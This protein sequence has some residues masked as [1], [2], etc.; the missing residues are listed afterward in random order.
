MIPLEQPEILAHII[1]EWIDEANTQVNKISKLKSFIYLDI[2][3]HTNL[4]T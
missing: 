1:V 3:L 2:G 4:E